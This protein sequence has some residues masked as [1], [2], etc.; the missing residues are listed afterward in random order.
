MSGSNAANE[1][2]PP[3]ESLDPA[4]LDR[5]VDGELTEAER[6]KLLASLDHLPTGWRQCALAFL[7][8]QSWREIFSSSA[9]RPAVEAPAKLP[10]AA[11]AVLEAKAD[12]AQPGQTRMVEPAAPKSSRRLS[13]HWLWAMEM[14]ASF[15]VVFSLGWM[16][17]GGKLITTNAQPSSGN[18]AQ[19]VISRSNAAVQQVQNFSPLQWSQSASPAPLPDQMRQAI[20]QSAQ[21]L[22]QQ[23]RVVP[24]E[25]PDGQRVLVP[26]DQIEVV[27]PSNR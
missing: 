14:A 17:R 8:A 7:E 25:F 22:R 27:P 1:S 10:V 20:E 2:D 13:K 19:S 15:L 24:L 23:R 11:A 4:L 18:V 21:M 26:V 16:I 5:L 3:R 12:L 9:K 6:H